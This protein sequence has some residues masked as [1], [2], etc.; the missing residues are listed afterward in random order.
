MFRSP[1]CENKRRGL[2]RSSM[3]KQV[4]PRT[5]LILG[6]KDVMSPSHP[7]DLSAILRIENGS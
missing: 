1:E 4:T 7:E 3:T 5:V 6:V 2:V